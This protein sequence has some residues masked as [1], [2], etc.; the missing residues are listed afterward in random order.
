MH[1]DQLGA[2]LGLCGIVAAR[3]GASRVILTDGDS[4]TLTRMRTNVAASARPLLPECRQLIWQ[5]RPNNTKNKTSRNEYLHRFLAQSNISNGV[6]LILGADICYME[7]SLEPLWN[8]MDHLLS[9]EAGGQVWLAYTFRNVAMDSIV[10]QAQEYG[11]VCQQTPSGGTT[12]GVYV[13]VRR[14]RLTMAATK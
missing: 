8:T 10:E 1:L 12:E 5:P 9:K 13:F 6:P 2:G 3:L 4:D 14:Q 7:E 11:F